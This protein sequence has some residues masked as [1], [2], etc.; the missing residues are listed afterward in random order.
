[1][2]PERL[3]RLNAMSLLVVVFFAG[4]SSRPDLMGA[5]ARPDFIQVRPGGKNG[6]SNFTLRTGMS[7]LNRTV[8]VTPIW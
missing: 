5:N 8:S 4:G 3:T 6:Y 1:M 2:A 7:D